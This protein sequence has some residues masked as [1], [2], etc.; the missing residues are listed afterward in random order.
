MVVGGIAGAVAV[1]GFLLA[2]FGII[3][4][5]GPLIAAIVAAACALL[6]RSTVSPR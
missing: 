4:A 3:G 6:F 5:G 2:I 1:V